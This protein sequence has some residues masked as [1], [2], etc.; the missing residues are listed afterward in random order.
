MG[1]GFLVDWVLCTF[2]VSFLGFLN[3]LG[4]IFVWGS[5]LGFTL[6]LH[7]FGMMF[8]IVLTEF[9]RFLV[10]VHRLVLGLFMGLKLFF[11]L[12]TPFA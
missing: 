3:R 9:L 1:G 7:S 10:E 6:A 12:R 4:F 8:V 5:F 2:W 11:V